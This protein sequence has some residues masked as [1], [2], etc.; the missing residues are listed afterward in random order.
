[1]NRKTIK[2]LNHVPQ[3]EKETIRIIL[4]VTKGGAVK[5]KFMVVLLSDKPTLSQTLIPDHKS[6]KHHKGQA[7]RNFFIRRSK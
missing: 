6:C 7:N 1:M 2:A 5:W 4:P 3:S